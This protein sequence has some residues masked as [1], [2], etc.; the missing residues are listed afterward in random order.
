MY[1]PYKLNHFL[2]FKGRQTF[3]LEGNMAHGIRTRKHVVD[4]WSNTC[5]NFSM[6]RSMMPVYVWV[7]QTSSPVT[8]LPS[9]SLI[10]LCVPVWWHE[11]LCVLIRKIKPC[12]DH[13]R[14][15]IPHCSSPPW[16]AGLPGQKRDRR[17]DSRV[18]VTPSVIHIPGRNRLSTLK[19]VRAID[20]AI[21]IMSWP[22][23][24]GHPW[25]GDRDSYNNKRRADSPWGS[26]EGEKE[27][28]KNFRITPC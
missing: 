9:F 6:T 21:F 13:R 28:T 26:R 10:C 20:E 17:E 3:A 27:I 5:D 24:H 23:F 11:S 2:V 25:P 12:R 14:G 18:R 19:R 15:S 16:I 22:W 4:R 7:K 1:F 8:S